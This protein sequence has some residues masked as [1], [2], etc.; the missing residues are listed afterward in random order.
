MTPRRALVVL[1]TLL[2]AALALTAPA[3]AQRPEPSYK[4]IPRTYDAALAHFE[5]ANGTEALKKF[6]TPSGNIYCNIGKAGPKGCE[7]NQ[8]SVKDPD[9]CPGNPVSDRVGRLE[10]R[11]NRVLPI[12]NTDTIRTRAQVL[13]YGE[14]TTSG[15]YA[16]ISERQGVTCIHRTKT[17]GFFLHKGEYVIFNAG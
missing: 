2:T 1:L 5:L 12:C 3:Q 4:G 17:L 7:I 6:V 13:E 16:C 11:G 8:G 9:A 15:K 10:F 14:A